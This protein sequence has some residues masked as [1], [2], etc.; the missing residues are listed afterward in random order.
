M[1]NM[2]LVL[3][4]LIPAT[5]RCA[6]LQER[7]VLIRVFISC[8]CFFGRCLALPC[9]ALPCLALP[10]LALPCLAL[11]CLALHSANSATIICN[12]TVN[13][14]CTQIVVRG[15]FS[16]VFRCSNDLGALQSV[17]LYIHSGD[18]CGHFNPALCSIPWQQSSPFQPSVMLYYC[19]TV[20]M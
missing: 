15:G 10:C 13:N 19:T 12:R 18:C 20:F 6:A 16:L 3:Y 1:L 9:L 2:C 17:T 5:S 8:V 4:V 7:V 11:P 14:G